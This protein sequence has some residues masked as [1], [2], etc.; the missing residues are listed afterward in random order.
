MRPWVHCDHGYILAW[1]HKAK[2]FTHRS[3]QAQQKWLHFVEN[4]SKKIIDTH[5]EVNSDENGF[6]SGRTPVFKFHLG[7]H[8]RSRALVHFS[9]LQSAH[10]KYTKNG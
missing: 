2:K 8:S 6:Q 3:Q 5:L 10:L 7:C 9:L 1:C 4:Y